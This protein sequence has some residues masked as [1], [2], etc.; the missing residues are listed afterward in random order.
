[1]PSDHPSLTLAHPVSPSAEG[2]FFS[3]MLVNGL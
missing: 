1:V 2:L 3:L